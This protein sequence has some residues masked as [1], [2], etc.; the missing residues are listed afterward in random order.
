MSVYFSKLVENSNGPHLTIFLTSWWL[1]LL[2]DVDVILACQFVKAFDKGLLLF[3]YF[4]I[5]SDDLGDQ[6][7]PILLFHESCVEKK[8]FM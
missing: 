8:S 7:R 1:I 5:Q 3:L 4:V 2:L 6:L